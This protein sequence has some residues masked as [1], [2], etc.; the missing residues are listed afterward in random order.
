MLHI[1]NDLVE[2]LTDSLGVHEALVVGYLD[3]AK[4]RGEVFS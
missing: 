2:S 3:W 1:C 4:F